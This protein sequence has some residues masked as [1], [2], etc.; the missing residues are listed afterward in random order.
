MFGQSYLI[1]NKNN[2]DPAYLFR[3]GNSLGRRNKFEND[4]AP[5]H[6]G[7]LMNK[8]ACSREHYTPPIH[9]T[10]QMFR[11][12][13]TYVIEPMNADQEQQL[14]TT[15]RNLSM[16]VAVFVLLIIAAMMMF[17]FYRYGYSKG[18]KY[19]KSKRG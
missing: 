13:Q 10:S 15:N 3:G 12:S 14:Q 5:Y 1:K 7:Y 18:K 2:T 16:A 4:N 11:H 19:K 17:G 6:S 9:T 8:K